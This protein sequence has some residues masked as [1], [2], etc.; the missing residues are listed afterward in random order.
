MNVI[1]AY[2]G[3]NRGRRVYGGEIILSD[4][5][6]NDGDDLLT[7][8]ASLVSAFEKI[9]ETHFTSS[10]NVHGVGQD[11]DVVGTNT[12]QTL[13]NK[14]I[15][16]QTAQ[17][18]SVRNISNQHIAT[19]QNIHGSKLDLSSINIHNLEGYQ[20]LKN[21]L[22]PQVIHVNSLTY[23]LQSQDVK[24]TF[25]V[26]SGVNNFILPLPSTL[27]TSLVSQRIWIVNYSTTQ[28]IT[29]TGFGST[30][31]NRDPTKT[32]FI[33]PPQRSGMFTTGYTQASPNYWYET[34]NMS[35]MNGMM[36]LNDTRS[37][38][39]VTPNALTKQLERSLFQGVELNSMGWN[40]SLGCY[41]VVTGTKNGRVVI[42]STISAENG[43]IARQRI[44]LFDIDTGTQISDN[45][46]TLSVDGDMIPIKRTIL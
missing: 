16:L 32:S 46:Y 9:P 18:N 28:N 36:L 31:L 27:S 4:T 20:N 17:G 35:L 44:E 8:I 37:N 26:C 11:S 39:Q 41:T 24:D 7:T 15:D 23:S 33:I 19:N 21:D 6:N 30:G 12:V 40:S 22:Q 38:V 42:R 1:N 13:K 10:K 5:Y 34:S 25:F 43:A 45:T 29:V 3:P 2:R 14:T